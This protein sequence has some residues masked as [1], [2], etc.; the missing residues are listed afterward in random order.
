MSARP[1][2]LLDTLISMG[3]ISGIESF[4]SASKSSGKNTQK[5]PESAIV[6]RSNFGPDFI[7]PSARRFYSQRGA[8]NYFE[9][10]RR[11]L[12]GY[13]GL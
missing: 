6:T 8:L 3:G 9:V 2:V 12:I 4:V 10:I 11:V 13:K 7:R 5:Q 1:R